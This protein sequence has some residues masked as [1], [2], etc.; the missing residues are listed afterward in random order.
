MNGRIGSWV[1]K[2][3]Q[4]QVVNPLLILL[5]LPLFETVLYPSLN[6]ARLLTRPLQKMATGGVLAAVA[7]IMSGALELQLQVRTFGYKVSLCTQTGTATSKG[8]P[9]HRSDKSGR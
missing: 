5:F 7:F 4:M 3:D 9:A 6:K 1:I 8:A 2:P